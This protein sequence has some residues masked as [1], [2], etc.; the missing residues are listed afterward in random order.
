MRGLPNAIFNPWVRWN[1]WPG[2]GQEFFRRRCRRS[3]KFTTG[4]HWG[5]QE[6]LQD[7]TEEYRVYYRTPLRSTEYI[8]E[9]ILNLCNDKK[10]KCCGKTKKNKECDK[11]SKYYK[12]NK[13]YCKI[14]AKDKKYK[15]PSPELHQ[16]RI[17]SLNFADLKLLANKYDFKYDKCRKSELVNIVCSCISTD[18]FEHIKK[19]NMFILK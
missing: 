17:K 18:F 6:L 19:K 9:D 7:T 10:Y 3:P 12:N 16:K 13:Y 15:I 14:H 8:T 5:V 11:N 2:P 4:H 1:T